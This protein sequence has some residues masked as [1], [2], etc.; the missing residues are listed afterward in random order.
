MKRR[1]QEYRISVINVLG[2][3]FVSYIIIYSLFKVS[4]ILLIEKA[5]WVS[6]GMA[7]VEKK[8]KK[9][10]ENKR[11]QCDR[12]VHFPNIIYFYGQNFLKHSHASSANV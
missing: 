1:F 10:C 8:K 5:L 12:G 4:R 3:D 11:H 9:T 6:L 7:N 2:D